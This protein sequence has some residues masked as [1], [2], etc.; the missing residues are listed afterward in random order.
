M[1]AQGAFNL[2]HRPKWLHVESLGD[3]KHNTGAVII[4]V[5]VVNIFEVMKK[6]RICP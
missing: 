5:M 6:V 1:H 2:D 3:L 4:M